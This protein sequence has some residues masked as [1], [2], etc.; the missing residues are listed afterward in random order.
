M[1]GAGMNAPATAGAVPEDASDTTPGRDLPGRL[2]TVSATYGTGGSVI[3]P[4]LAQRL[5]V[6]FLARVTGPPEAL[7][8]RHR[9][10]EAL[11]IEERKTIPVHRLLASLTHAMPVGPTLSP[12]SVHHQHD[13][14]RRRSEAEI[15]SF[16]AAGG[17]VILG[18]AAAVVLGKDRGF[19]VR[20]DGPIARRVAQ[21]ATVEHVDLEESRAHLRAADAARTAYVRRLYGVD[22]ADASLYHLMIDTTAIPLEDAIELI[23]GAVRSAGAA[24]SA[25]ASPASYPAPTGGGRATPG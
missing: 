23:L 10:R 22:P 2:I 24:R 1:T 8:D 15:A 19:H 16:A 5:G 17:G 4:A 9:A 25:G 12:P 13:Q 20:L 7:A 11:S 6:S 18:R 21:G 14:L 3:A